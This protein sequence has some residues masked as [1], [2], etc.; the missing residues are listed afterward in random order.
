MPW[1][2]EFDLLS[3][4]RKMVYTTPLFK[5]GFSQKT[6]FQKGFSQNP[7]FQK[8]FSQNSRFAKGFSQIR[9]FLWK[10][11]ISN[12]NSRFRISLLHFL[13][14]WR[15]FQLMKMPKNRVK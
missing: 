9:V 8:G 1:S 11:T 6:R 3:K 14:F 4:P 10:K 7:R 5:K 12:S 15:V 13:L 2:N